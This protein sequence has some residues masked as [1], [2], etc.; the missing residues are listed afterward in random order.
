MRRAS[1]GARYFMPILSGVVAIV[2]DDAYVL[3]ALQRALQAFG[4]RVKVFAT[5]EK[6][7]EEAQQDEISCVVIDVNLGRGFSGLDLAEAI[8]A[9][10]PTPIMFMSAA[11]NELLLD[12]ARRIG[13]VDLLHKPFLVSRLI[14]AIM[15]LDGDE[16]A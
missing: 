14:E 15:R 6:Y 11:W 4:Y 5:A 16:C 8:L 10:R 2:D 1:K 3:K 12:R 13:C 7:F 9:A